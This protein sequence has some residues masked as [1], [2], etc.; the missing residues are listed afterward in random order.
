MDGLAALGVAANICQF[1]EYGLKLA[2]KVKKLREIGAIDPDLDRDARQLK[3]IARNLSPQ[4]LPQNAGDIGHLAVECV[5]VSEA[6]I[7]ELEQLKPKD[8][9]S[10]W[11]GFKAIIKSERKKDY[12]QEL[13]KKLGKCR[14]QLSL[15][16]IFLSRSEANENLSKLSQTGQLIKSELA[17]L[18]S[19]ANSVNGWSLIGE[20]I[21]RTLQSLVQHYNE[22]L[23]KSRQ[24]TVLNMLR[25]P[26]MHERFDT[27][28]NAH[29]KTFRWLLDNPLGKSSTS[30]TVTATE[31]HKPTKHPGPD[32]DWFL[33]FDEKGAIKR[34]ARK[35][36]IAWLQEQTGFFHISGKPGAGKSTLMKYICLHPDLTR[37]LQVWC[38]GA[39]LGLGKFF[40][41]RPGHVAQRSLKGLLC[42]LLHSILEKNR[43][44]IPTAFPELWDLLLTQ[45]AF[46]RELEYRDFEQGLENIFAQ[47]SQDGQYKFALFIDGLDEF[48]GRHLDLI[49]TM[50]AWLKQYPGVLKICVSSREYSV[51]QESFSL[52][53]K[54]RLHE[55]TFMDIAKMVSARLKSNTYYAALVAEGLKSPQ[56]N[57]NIVLLIVERAEGVFLWVSLVLAAIEDG[58][59]SGDNLCELRQKVEAYPTELEP[60]YRHLL[61][62]IHTTDRRWAFRALKMVRFFQSNSTNFLEIGPRSAALSDST[63]LTDCIKVGLLQ[64]SFLDDVEWPLSA[65][66]HAKTQGPNSTEPAQ[67]LA[68]TYKKVYGRCKGFLEIQTGIGF[69]VPEVVRQHVVLTHRSVIEFLET[70]DV[71]EMTRP[72][73][74]DFD[75]FDG[76]CHTLLSCIKYMHPTALALHINYPGEPILPS[77][78]GEIMSYYLRQTIE[79]YIRTGIGL[80]RSGT[81]NFTAFLDSIGRILSE[82]FKMLGFTPNLLDPHQYL[83]LKSLSLGAFEYLKWVKNKHQEPR[84]PQL[85]QS[86]LVSLF[87][88]FYRFG[89]NSRWSYYNMERLIEVLSCFLSLGLDLN[90]CEA[91]GRFHVDGHFLGSTPWQGFLWDFMMRRFPKSWC[92]GTLVDWFLRHGAD[93]SLTVSKMT[94]FG[95]HSLPWMFPKEGWEVFRPYS[96]ADISF[97]SLLNGRELLRP[98]TIVIMKSTAPLC[99]ATKAHGGVLKLCDLMVHWFPEDAMYFQDLID[100]LLASKR[101]KQ[102]ALTPLPVRTKPMTRKIWFQNGDFRVFDEAEIKWELSAAG[103]RA[104]DLDERLGLCD[105]AREN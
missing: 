2:G 13:E 69:G 104:T 52:C 62:S 22:S 83:A 84:F 75:C 58:L 87:Y 74:S 10:K 3:D 72:Y 76:A 49:E 86:Y 80:Q 8:P 79:V 105:L 71:V 38:E 47:A 73:V 96:E 5:E 102:D 64:L 35:H 88:E 63:S 55:L 1:L 31:T 53:P 66:E 60:L 6:L 93:P 40:F 32:T 43:N 48:D 51:F 56:Y 28:A 9:K 65:F 90:T 61:H 46:P 39:R 89:T 29:E 11:Q 26:D 36:F 27:V 12:I 82:H 57:S 33:L 17:M 54:L 92:L 18:N 24:T 103:V 94:P 44:L 45:P 81:D 7:T 42:G 50:K 77:S 41:W 14:D 97:S 99:Q 91:Q 67:R 25:F 85:G 30:S 98:D 4:S 19:I 95:P 68:N 34:S 37:H 78:V 59:M 100:S 15:H 21:R 70:P 23:V 101:G 16:L 20:D